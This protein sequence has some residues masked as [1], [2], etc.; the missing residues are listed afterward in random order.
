MAKTDDLWRLEV[1]QT[2]REPRPKTAG[3]VLLFLL[4]TLVAVALAQTA[5]VE[6]GIAAVVFGA[7]T[8]M[9]AMKLHPKNATL[10]LDEKGFRFASLFRETYVPW[11]CVKEFKPYILS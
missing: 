7:F 8:L 4:I 10:H 3:L 2:F 11:E 5:P 1:P 9:L 6:G